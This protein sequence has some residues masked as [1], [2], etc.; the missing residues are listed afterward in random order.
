MNL[1]RLAVRGLLVLAA[2]SALAGSLRAEGEVIDFDSDQWVL[3]GGKVV[4]QLGRRCLTG[5]AYL[6]SADFTDGVIEFDLA[7]DGRRSY[8]GVAFR[9][10]PDGN[11][12]QFYVRPHRAPTYPDALQY[13]PSMNGV[14]GWQLYSGEGFTA[15]AELTADRW[16]H[17]RLEVKGSQARVFL[18]KGIEPALA[19]P[20]LQHGISSGTIG[21]MSPADDTAWFSNFSYREDGDLAFDEP[22]EIVTP[23]GSILD[24]EISRCYPADQVE[25]DV[26][27]GFIAL[28]DAG[29]EK[30]VADATGL[31]DVARYRQRDPRRADCVLARAVLYSGEKQRVKLSFGYSDDVTFFLNSRPVFSGRNGYR[32][33]DPS[34]VGVVGLFDTVFLDLER[35]RNELFMVLSEAFGGW[36]FRAQTD[37]LLDAPPVDDACADKVWETEPVFLTPES[38]QHDPARDVLYVS[39]FDIDFQSKREPSGFISRL[40]LDGE[41]LDLKWVTGLTGPCGMDLRA[42]RLFVAER[43]SL[44]E[45]DVESGEITARYPVPGS[46]FLNDVAVDGA[47]N[48]YVSD[49]FP[50]TPRYHVTVFRL[51]GGNI[52][53]WLEDDRISRANGL[54]CW[55]D[56]LL[57]GNTGDGT[58]KSIDLATR[59]I[60]TIAGLGGGV[61]DGIRVEEDGDYLVSLWQGQV[62]RVSAEGEVVMLL[63]TGLDMRN[64]ADFEFVQDQSLL[65]VPTFLDNRVAAYRIKG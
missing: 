9:V 14:A 11:H 51:A 60:D 12:E 32:S 63:D 65:I 31:V 25:R 28:F 23:P 36:G 4:D 64:T 29:W 15:A 56:R 10:Q 6:R 54:F 18:D 58:L 40:S 62:F 22:P 7:V 45:I 1:R 41:I 30:V 46:R 38:V 3:D 19:I 48:V 52:E 35:G 21:L 43:G 39:S 27:P 13:V 50:T 17:V 2:S 42:D 26:Y 8:P 5:S 57:L 47:G 59:R 44:T 24:W 61:V 20:H 49:S 16:I 53:E 55:S 37:V 34:Y 33:R